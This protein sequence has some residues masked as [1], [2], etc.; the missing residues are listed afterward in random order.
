MLIAALADFQILIEFLVIRA[1]WSIWD[2]LSRGPP[3]FPLL[4][5]EA[6]IFG[7]FGKAAA[8]V[9]DGGVTANSGVPDSSDFW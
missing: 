9:A 1:S 5:F 6:A 3:G 7:F 8:D 2:I 4:D